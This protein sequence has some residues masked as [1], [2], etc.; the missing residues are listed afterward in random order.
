MKLAKYLFLSVV[1][2]FLYE[3]VFGLE[4]VVEAIAVLLCCLIFKEFEK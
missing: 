1:M 4:M 2:V 3:W